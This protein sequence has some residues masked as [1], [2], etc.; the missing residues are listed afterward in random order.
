MPKEITTSTFPNDPIGILP[1]GKLNVVNADDPPFHPNVVDEEG[2]IVE[3]GED[4]PANK[5]A[6][7]SIGWFNAHARQAA[8]ER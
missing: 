6:T 8:S 4:E 1:N 2:N 3:I 5:R 7:I